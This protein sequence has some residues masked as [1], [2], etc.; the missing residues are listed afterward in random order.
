MKKT[1]LYK[2]I[3]FALIIGILFTAFSTGSIAAETNDIPKA[4]YVDLKGIPKAE[5]YYNDNYFTESGKV[6]SEHLASMSLNLE[7]AVCEKGNT[8]VV[9][10]LFDEIG[11]TDIVLDELNEH[12]TQRTIGTA[13]ASKK[14]GSSNLIAVAIRGDGYEN[15]WASNV[16]VG[17]DGNAQGFETAS[18]KVADR[19]RKYINDN[20]LKN[21]KFWIVGYSRAGAVA[22]LTGVYLN[23]HLDDFDTN[24]DNLYVYTFSAPAGSGENVVYDNIYNIININDVVPFTYPEAWGLYSNGKRIEIAVSS[25]IM[26]YTMP[27]MFSYEENENKETSVFL[28]EFFNWFTSQLSR[29]EYAE[30][31]Q[32]PL[33]AIM[34]IYFLKSEEG[35]NDIVDFIKND[36]YPL[37]RDDETFKKD[38]QLSLDEI[39]EKNSDCVYQIL[40]ERIN[41]MLDKLFKKGELKDINYLELKVIEG[42]VYPIVRTLGPVF[43]SDYIYYEGIDYDKYYEEENPLYNA[44]DYD[45]GYSKG[46]KAGEKQGYQYGIDPSHGEMGSITQKPEVNYSK[47]YKNGYADGAKAGYENGFNKAKSHLEN[48]AERGYYDGYTEA[49]SLEVGLN[50]TEN[51][52]T[53]DELL[54]NKSNEDWITEEY[55]SEY[56]RGY[57]EKLEENK[58]SLL[59]DDGTKRRKLPCYHIVSFLKNVTPIITNHYTQV[60]YAIVQMKDSYYTNIPST[61]MIGDVDFDNKITSADS[62]LQLRASVGLENFNNSQ[63]VIGDVDRNSEITSYDALLTLRASVNLEKGTAIG[64]VLDK[65]NYTRKS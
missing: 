50:D 44:S 9:S 14:I 23:K 40:A 33:S 53:A 60:N 6:Y 37:L 2:S 1:N 31:V 26:T 61:L 13:I 29:E 12:P 56:T 18:L 27:A 7:L 64:T 30:K 52:P 16:I 41:K 8:D 51:T 3:S 25:Q 24:T 34:D 4:G 19:I 45:W 28:S 35:R 36:F 42:S 43:V 48:L 21:N 15:E 22:D 55:K 47:E 49:E 65:I 63:W 57:N 62:L 5:Y 59:N 39:T 10:S 11:F 38:M 58:R 20:N 46:E 32:V 54:E 17:K